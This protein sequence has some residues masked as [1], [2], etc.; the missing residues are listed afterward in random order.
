MDSES[1]LPGDNDG[2]PSHDSRGHNF[3]RS[4]GRR[5]RRPSPPA[6]TAVK[7]RGKNTITEH[8][9][10][11][12]EDP[13]Q[14]LKVVPAEPAA[15]LRRPHSRRS[16]DNKSCVPGV[17]V[18]SRSEKKATVIPAAQDSISCH[19]CASLFGP[20]SSSPLIVRLNTFYAL[21]G[22]HACFGGRLTSG[23]GR[24]KQDL[25]FARNSLYLVLEA[26]RLRHQSAVQS[27]ASCI[28]R[29]DCRA[30]TRKQE[31]GENVEGQKRVIDRRRTN[32]DAGCT[33]GAWIFRETVVLHLATSKGGYRVLPGDSLRVFVYAKGDRF[34]DVCRPFSKHRL[35]EHKSADGPL[36]DDLVGVATLPLIRPVAGKATDRTGTRDCECTFLRPIEVSVV[37]VEGAAIGFL[38]V[39]LC[40]MSRD[41]SVKKPI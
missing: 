18:P 3:R 26:G 37:S 31:T 5:A 28:E 11:D 20:A 6:F 27:P 25:S 29:C 2:L 40:G 19:S 14:P 23:D 35:L 10:E 39:E 34:P 17:G 8:Q 4:S 16:V 38:E 15:V 9:D 24:S 21:P 22:R 1:P 13:R 7:I 32:I 30:N 41:L 36:A 12:D 33:D